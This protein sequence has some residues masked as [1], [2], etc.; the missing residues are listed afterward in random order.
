M[1]VPFDYPFCSELYFV[2]KTIHVV[3]RIAGDD[4]QIRI[5]ALHNPTSPIAFSTRSYIHERVTNDRGEQSG[6]WVDYDLPWTSGDSADE[7]LQK[8]LWLLGE[9]C[10]KK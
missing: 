6:R 2:E 9:R 7:V 3:A 8:V 5:E 1:L 10:P 4:R